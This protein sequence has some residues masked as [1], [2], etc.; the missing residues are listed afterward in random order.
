MKYLIGLLILLEI[1][2]GLLTHF[3]VSDGLARE[4][5]PFLLPLVGDAGFMVLKIVG[6]LICAVILWDIYRRYPRLALVS[7]T[8]F[9]VFYG[10]IVLWN[11]SLFAFA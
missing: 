11:L 1:S 5:N 6:V 10:F 7:T 4:A 3:L 8:C 2:D 9:V